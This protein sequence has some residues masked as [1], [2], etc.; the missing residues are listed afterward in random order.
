MP[1]SRF[2]KAG[3]A[4]LF[5]AGM[6]CAASAQA[7]INCTMHYSMKG[8]SAFYKTASGHGNV[9]CSDGSNSEVYLSSV[10]GGLTLGVSSIDDGFGQ[11]SGIH[12][13]GEIYGD[14]AAGEAHGA[15]GNAGT[16]SVVSKGEVSLALKGTGH[17][18]D[19]G[20]DFTKFSIREVPPPPPVTPPA[21]SP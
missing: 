18:I 20:V 19:A 7:D 6:F 12:S 1:A 4:L 3:A 17:G 14:Y 2:P 21:S 8:W 16:V 9:S 13:I 5:A 10:G 15:A 11:F